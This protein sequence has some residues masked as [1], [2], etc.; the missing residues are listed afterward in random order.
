MGTCA[1]PS[2]AATATAT[3]PEMQT[4]MATATANTGTRVRRGRHKTGTWHREE[5][6]GR[7]LDWV[8]VAQGVGVNCYVPRGTPD[9]WALLPPR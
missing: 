6:K 4:A 8:V 9:P 1:A 3:L 5:Q 2:W 7:G